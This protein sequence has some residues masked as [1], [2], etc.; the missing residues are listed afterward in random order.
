MKKAPAL[1]IHIKSKSGKIK[2]F[3]LKFQKKIL[4]F[5]KV[6]I[7]NNSNVN[8]PLKTFQGTSEKIMKGSVFLFTNF[9]PESLLEIF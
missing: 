4:V 5:F 3:Y 9:F 8:T 6:L 1:E 2:C 7:F